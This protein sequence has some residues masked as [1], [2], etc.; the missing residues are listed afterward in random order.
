MGEQKE[1]AK[2]EGFKCPHCGSTET[3]LFVDAFRCFGCYP[4]GTD[5]YDL[6]KRVEREIKAAALGS[7]LDAWEK[8]D[9]EVGMEN[10]TGEWFIYWDQIPELIEALARGDSND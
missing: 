5:F 10:E 7:L 8:L 4:R 9:T 2:F 6:V 1:R 3:A